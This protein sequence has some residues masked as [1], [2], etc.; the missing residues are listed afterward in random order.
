[1]LDEKAGAGF[2]I[3]L[4]LTSG[5]TSGRFSGWQFRKATS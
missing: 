3:V 4:L 2:P 5:G 1:M